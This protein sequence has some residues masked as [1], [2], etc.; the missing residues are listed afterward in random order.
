MNQLKMIADFVVSSINQFF[1][2]LSESWF[3]IALLSLIVLD[4]AISVLI[5]LRGTK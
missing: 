1:T 5:I 4:I 3:G 2:T